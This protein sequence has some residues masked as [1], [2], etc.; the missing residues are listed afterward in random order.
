ML[1]LVQYLALKNWLWI[2]FAT[3]GIRFYNNYYLLMILKSI[4]VI[5][6]YYGVLISFKNIELYKGERND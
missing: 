4:L 2:V 6:L 3:A 1:I 5:V